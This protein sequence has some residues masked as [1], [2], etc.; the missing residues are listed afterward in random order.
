MVFISRTRPQSDM[1]GAC[2]RSV[3]WL[4]T[5]IMEMGAGRGGET[6][7]ERDQAG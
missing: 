1:I 4:Q 6:G 5:E 3:E 7:S 2:N